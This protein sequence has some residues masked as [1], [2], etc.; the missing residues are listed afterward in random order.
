MRFMKL[1]L[2]LVGFVSVPVMADQ[3]VADKVKTL[4]SERSF[5]GCPELRKGPNA[6]SKGQDV[7]F[8]DCRSLP[9]ELQAILPSGA[10]RVDDKMKE[11]I[12]NSRK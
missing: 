2:L 5:Q 6:E 4:R 11:V 3:T 8:E 12:R 7:S 1:I 9:A 10:K